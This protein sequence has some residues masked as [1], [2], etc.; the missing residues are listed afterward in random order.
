MKASSTRTVISVLRAAK[1]PSVVL[2]NELDVR[3]TEAANEAKDTVQFF[4]SLEKYTELLHALDPR[5]CREIIA[6]KLTHISRF[7]NIS[8]CSRSPH[9]ISTL[10]ETVTKRMIGGCC[11]SIG[12][13]GEFPERDR[14]EPDEKLKLSDC[15]GLG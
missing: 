4:L 12:E 6:G 10:L 13:K 7:A 9:R 3:V 8:G 15:I 2:L 5:E 11:G 1:R 14:H